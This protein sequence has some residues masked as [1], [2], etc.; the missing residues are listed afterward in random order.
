MRV[1]HFAAATA[2]VAAAGSGASKNKNKKPQ[3]QMPAKV[4]KVGPHGGYE[5]FVNTHTHTHADSAHVCVYYP[6]KRTINLSTE[7]I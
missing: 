1:T 6:I 3:R 7:H 4:F 5:L 2:A